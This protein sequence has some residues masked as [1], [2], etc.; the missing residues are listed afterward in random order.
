MSSR[1]KD[2]RIAFTR[3]GARV[4][5]NTP[6]RAHDRAELIRGDV[7]LRLND[8]APSGL[9]HRRRF[10]RL[11]ASPLFVLR[12]RRRSG[13]DTS[14]ATKSVRTILH[15]AREVATTDLRFRLTTAITY[16][17][18]LKVAAGTRGTRRSGMREPTTSGNARRPRGSGRRRPVGATQSHV[19]SRRIEELS[20]VEPN[21]GCLIWRGPVDRDGYGRTRLGREQL[22]H[23]VALT[24]A[25][26]PIGPAQ[27]NARK[28]HCKRGHE[29]TDQNTRH[30][31]G[32][33]H[34]RACAA[35]R[36]SVRSRMSV[37]EGVSAREVG[38]AT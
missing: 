21:T 32:E 1:T 7:T 11:L 10:V 5:P 8:E 15:T 38:C 26:G 35:T 13:D 25:C 23:R 33:R 36:V 9:E 17:R 4:A 16:R 19:A 20:H 27:V 34:C 30:Y 22:A 37:D 12:H 3:A 18:R 31:R 14:I 24:L 6:T 29:F 28:T 2:L